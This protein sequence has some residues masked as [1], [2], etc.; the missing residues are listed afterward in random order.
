M[1][2]LL[3]CQLLLYFILFYF[4]L[5]YFILPNLFIL[6]W[7]LAVQPDRPQFSFISLSA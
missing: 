5:F 4:I 7:G 1:N 6:R 3:S 2:G